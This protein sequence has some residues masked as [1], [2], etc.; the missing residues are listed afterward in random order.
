MH[1]LV[2]I[3]L[4]VLSTF[5]AKTAV[6]QQETTYHNVLAYGATQSKEAASTKAIQ[7]AIDSCYYQGGGTVY[8]PPGAYCS[9]TIVL[10]DNVTLFLE[11]GATLFAS[12]NLQDYR[13]PLQYALRPTLIYANGARN[14]GIKGKGTIHGQA[15]RTYEALKGTDRFIKDFTEIARNSGVE[16]KQYYVAPPAAGLF[17]LVDCQDIRVENISLVESAYWTLHI[18]K[19]NRIFIHGIRINSSLEQGVNSDGIDINSCQDVVISDCIISTGDDAIVLKS[20]LK[21]PCENITVTNCVLTSSSTAL[22]LGTESEGDFKHILFNNCSVRNSNRGLSIVVRDGALVEDVVFSNITIECSRRHFNWWGN[23]DPIWIFLTKR[24]GKSRIG[25]IKDVVFENI[26]AR[27]MGT[28]KIESTLGMQI[29][30]IRLNNVQFFM[31]PESKPD[32]RADHAF[33]ANHVNGLQLN[34][35]SVVWEEA[36]TEKKW[37][38]AVSISDAKGVIID[39][40]SGRQGLIDSPF[41]VIEL[42]NT[43]D[44]L[45]RNCLPATHANTLVMVTGEASRNM[46]LQNN[47]PF[48]KAKKILE[49]ASGVLPE[50]AI[51]LVD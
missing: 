4:L 38:S 9:G 2:S 26:I 13:S 28:S 43:S 46:I 6:A 20:W 24:H 14:I 31:L 27:G 1:C 51:Q 3:A 36:D 29:E 11:A 45:I 17:T 19:S 33:A 49:I 50:N 37:K 23:G 15:E 35:V 48:K 44:V 8:F 32:K 30:N 22:K 47:D 5:S 40:F 39:N 42:H 34:D 16:M 21:D 10:K 41:P 18:I 7:A 12:R 25:K